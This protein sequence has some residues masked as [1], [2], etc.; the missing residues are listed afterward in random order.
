M[1]AKGRVT[2]QAV[3]GGGAEVGAVGWVC[4]RT[5]MHHVGAHSVSQCCSTDKMSQHNGK[6]PVAFFPHTCGTVPS[7]GLNLSSLSRIK[8]HYCKTFM[9]IVRAT[10]WTLHD[11]AQ[12]AIRAGA[13]AANAPAAPPRSADLIQLSVA[14][15][16]ECRARGYAVHSSRCTRLEP[17]VVVPIKGHIEFCKRDRLQGA[18]DNTE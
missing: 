14:P 17:V 18:R 5:S 11:A 8:A 1:S 3:W 6:G 15:E 4:R 10:A 13:S 9:N 2:P 12:N 16:S 7:I